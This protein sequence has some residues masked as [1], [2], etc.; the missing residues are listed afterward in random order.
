MPGE[1]GYPGSPGGAAAEEAV[2]G[3]PLSRR[4]GSARRFT[5]A[6]KARAAAAYED[7]GDTIEEF[8][9]AN[10]V[11]SASLCKWR[12]Q[13]ASGGRSGAR[14]EAA[15]GN[16]TGRTRRPYTPEER[17]QAIEA[18][19]KSG[20]SVELFTELWGVSAKTFLEWQQRLEMEGPKGLEP[21]KRGRPTGTVCASPIPTT[22]QAEIVETKKKFPWFG[23]RK[24][25]DFLFR[26]RGM[27]VSP[28]GVGR[29]ARPR[30]GAA[31][32]RGEERGRR[33]KGPPQAVRAGEPDGPL[34]ERHHELLPRE[35]RAG[36]CT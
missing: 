17:R 3:A 21:R 20:L 35:A 12:R 14:A 34:A 6:E 29:D 7:S 18:Y 13:F 22:V 2:P 31:Q 8:C 1:P 27:K 16:R 9:R 4:S 36:G 11:T 5:V 25:R 30:R 24:L 23:L 32:E 28:G 15:P 10:G 19:E 26:F 33:K